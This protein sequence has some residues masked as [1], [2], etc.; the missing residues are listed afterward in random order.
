MRFL[1]PDGLFDWNMVRVPPP[2]NLLVLLAV[3]SMLVYLGKAMLDPAS[4]KEWQRG[5]SYL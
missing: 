1:Q 5:T 3:A 2:I 4:R